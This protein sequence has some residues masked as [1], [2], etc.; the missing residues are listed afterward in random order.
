MDFVLGLWIMQ[1]GND[2]IF[3][4]VIFFYMAHFIPSK[5]MS[6]ATH[7]AILF[8]KEIVRLHGLPKIVTLERDNV[9]LGLFWWTFWKN[10]VQNCSIV[11]L[12]LTNKGANKGG[13][14]KLR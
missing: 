3:V 2:S 10:W 1:R 5:N 8:F 14:H 6:Y 13:Q 4:V 12:S 7:V 11:S 9:F